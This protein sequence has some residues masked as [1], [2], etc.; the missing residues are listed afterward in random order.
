MRSYDDYKKATQ[1]SDDVT[2]Y[3]AARWGD[4]V[5]FRKLLL[6]NR[7]ILE[8][9]NHRGYTAFMLACYHGHWELVE[10]FLKAGANPD[11]ADFSGNSVLMGA[12][13]KGNRKVV[14]ILIAG[15]ANIGLKNDKGQTAV[16]FAQMF[17]RHEVLSILSQDAKV[18]LKDKLKA[19]I[20]FLK[21]SFKRRK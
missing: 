9:R 13:F 4:T 16:D 11:D 14:E 10:L 8:Y 17:G 21:P 20:L 12:A 19:W 18:N 2:V 3:E 5:Y 1:S 6:E 15:G 7:E